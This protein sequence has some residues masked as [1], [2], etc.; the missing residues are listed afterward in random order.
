MITENLR[1]PSALRASPIGAL[2]SADIR[3][4][5]QP[6]LSESH[7]QA[8]E[9][10]VKQA[11]NI[12]E[13]LTQAT[14]PEFN[15]RGSLNFGWERSE[16][17]NAGAAKFGVGHD[18]LIQIAIGA[19]TTLLAMAHEIWAHGERAPSPRTLL[20]ED[21]LDGHM[22]PGEITPKAYK[23]A[24]D[25]TCLLYFHELSHVLWNHC[26]LDWEGTPSTDRR[27][28]EYQADNHAAL[29]FV[30]WKAG[31]ANS[32]QATNW[33]AIAEDLVL[34]ALLLSTAL[35]GFSA[36][37]DDYHFP[38]TR[39]FAFMG[40]GFRAIAELC[41]KRSE[42]LPFPDIEAEQ[43]FLF[44]P[45]LAFL[46]L[47]RATALRRLAGTEAEIVADV[48]QMHTVTVPREQEL[49]ASMGSLWALLDKGVSGD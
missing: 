26:Q 13:Q 6:E 16:T 23:V 32:G 18:Y 30:S 4:T 48:E 11:A 39:L 40:G 47:L 15:G 24:L 29:T 17:F 3:S 42:A 21:I 27:A 19:P 2:S 20:E 34:A 9:A 37:S 33:H 35:K 41:T 36:P 49:D 28:L 22:R 7:T 8:A 14:V 38:T 44:S 10:L 5:L 12:L 25:A 46:E 31:P 43:A 1:H 45:M